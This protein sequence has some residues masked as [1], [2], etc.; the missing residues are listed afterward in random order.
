MKID[1]PT[2]FDNVLDAAIED[3]ELYIAARSIEEVETHAAN[4]AVVKPLQFPLQRR[5]V[6]PSNPAKIPAG[7]FDRI[8]GRR[9]IQAVHARLHDDGALDADDMNHLEIVLQGSGGWR[10]LMRRHK[11]K[12]FRRTED[13][14]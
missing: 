4:A 6:N 13:V 14:E 5:F 2:Q 10:V 8:E 7:V 9:I 11:R 12:F 3:V 1:G